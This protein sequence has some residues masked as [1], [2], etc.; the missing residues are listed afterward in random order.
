MLMARP[1]VYKDPKASSILCKWPA[2]SSTKWRNRGNRDTGRSPKTPK[3]GAFDANGPPFRLQSGK[4]RET[5]IQDDP[6]RL[7]N[8]EHLMLLARPFVYK[9]PQ[10]WSI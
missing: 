10:A 6:Q 7:P 8:L 1:F 9:D 4:T 5:G 3:P 2:L